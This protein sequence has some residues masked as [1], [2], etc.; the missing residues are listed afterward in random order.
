VSS[1]LVHHIVVEDQSVVPGLT[2]NHYLVMAT[3]GQIQA[4]WQ[5]FDLFLDVPH[6]AASP[7]SAP[8]YV[9][10]APVEPGSHDNI[11]QELAKSIPQIARFA[12]PEYDQDANPPPPPPD[13]AP[14]INRFDQYAM[15]PPAFQNYTFSLTLQSGV[16]VHGHVRRYLPCHIGA[17]SRY[18][19]GRRGERALV[20]LTRVTG[21]DFIY[22]AVLK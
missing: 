1:N 18:D 3:Q 16:R 9:I 7:L 10:P 11:E 5:F 22:A 8:Q 2:L 19:V 6:P 20:I 12:F 13:Q 17:K 21:A 15:Q 14:P 4:P